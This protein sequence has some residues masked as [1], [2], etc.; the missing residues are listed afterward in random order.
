MPLVLRIQRVSQRPVVQVDVV[1]T[2]NRFDAHSNERAH[3]LV[4]EALEQQFL[5]D[6]FAKSPAATA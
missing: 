5:A 2:V 1:L 3:A 4:A 6:L